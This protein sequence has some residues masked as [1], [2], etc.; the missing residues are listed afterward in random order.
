VE[1]GRLVGGGNNILAFAVTSTRRSTLE[2]ARRTG[3][4]DADADAGQ[5]DRFV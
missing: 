2:Q 1:S 4:A 5:R 3:D